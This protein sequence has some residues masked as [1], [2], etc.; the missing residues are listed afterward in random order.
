MLKIKRAK[1][2]N[3]KIITQIKVQAFNKETRDFGTGYDRKAI[4]FLQITFP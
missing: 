2:E 3:A 4:Y 1:I